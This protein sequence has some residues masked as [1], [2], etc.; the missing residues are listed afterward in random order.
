MNKVSVFHK[1]YTCYDIYRWGSFYRA[2]GDGCRKY[3]AMNKP[4]E[5]WNITSKGQRPFKDADTIDTLEAG[6]AQLNGQLPN[7][8]TRSQSHHLV[9]RLI[10]HLSSGKGRVTPRESRGKGRAE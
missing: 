2:D 3:R 4:R 5:W 9:M 1:N 7:G 6:V 10:D 8:H